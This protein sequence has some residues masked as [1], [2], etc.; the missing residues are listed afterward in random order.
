VTST[1]MREDTGAGSKP[2]V[3][4]QQLRPDLGSLRDGWSVLGKRSGCATCMLRA[5]IVLRRPPTCAPSESRPAHKLNTPIPN[6]DTRQASRTAAYWGG[7]VPCTVYTA[8]NTQQGRWGE[9]NSV[10]LLGPLKANWV[11][12]QSVR[13]TSRCRRH[14]ALSLCTRCHART[15]QCSLQLY[16]SVRRQLLL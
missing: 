4:V 10:G 13:S 16:C 2:S 3:P 12:V 7:V 6:W 1:L 8:L 15:T 5:R 11:G 14:W 9:P